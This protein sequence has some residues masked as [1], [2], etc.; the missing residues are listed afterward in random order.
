MLILHSQPNGWAD[1]PPSEMEH[2]F[3]KYQSWTNKLRD[4]DRLVSSEKLGEEGGR[5]LTMRKGKLSTVDGPYAEAKEVVGGYMVFRAENY[6][7][8]LEL[9]KD[10]PHLAYGG[11]LELRQTDPIGCGGE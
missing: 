6:D 2:V 9:V 10:C 5:V 4:S 11:R 8:A 1:I 7:E 3:E